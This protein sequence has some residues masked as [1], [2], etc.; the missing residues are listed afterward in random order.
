MSQKDGRIST[1]T[2]LCR[3]DGAVRYTLLIPGSPFQNPKS[4]TNSGK[5]QDLG[6]RQPAL[7]VGPVNEPLSRSWVV[8]STGSTVLSG[9]IRRSKPTFDIVQFLF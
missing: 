2:T 3:Y 1:V 6:T 9:M 5:P 4:L 8:S 7:K